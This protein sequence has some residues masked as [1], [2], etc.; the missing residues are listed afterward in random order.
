MKK[1]PNYQAEAEKYDNPIPS[2]EFILQ[3][4]RDHKTPMS[5]ADIFDRTSDSR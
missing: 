3:T 4:I 1:D 2:R 5:R